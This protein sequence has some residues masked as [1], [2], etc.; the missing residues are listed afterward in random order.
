MIYIT[1]EGRTAS[2]NDNLV[3][4]GDRGLVAMLNALL[5]TINPQDS[6]TNP[7]AYL[8]Y[9]LQDRGFNV[10][11]DPEDLVLST[12]PDGAVS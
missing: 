6:H 9:D 1:S 3:V 5:K 2:I 11:C 8:Y 10:E 4:S 7:M 12:L